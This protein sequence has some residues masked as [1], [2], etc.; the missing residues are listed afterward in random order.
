MIRIDVL[1]SEAEIAREFLSGLGRRYLEE[2]FFYWFPLSVRA[3]LRLCGDVAY[4]NFVRSQ[5]LLRDS[6]PDVARRL[7]PGPVTVVSLGSG[8]GVKDVLVLESLRASGREPD[9]A[10]VD[11][12]QSLLE[13]ACLEA[14]GRGFACRGVKADLADAAHLE[15]LRPAPNDSPRL[16][17]LLGNTLGAFDPLALA[18]DVASLLRASDRLLIDGEIFSEA[19][20]MAGYDNPINREFAS[21]PL[22]AAGLTEPADGALTFF[23]ESDGRLEG[24]HRVRK[25][26]EVG[27]A[28]ELFLA[29]ESL[30][31]EAGE[32]IEM[33]WS[34]KYSVEAFDAVLARGG[35][36]ALASYPSGDGCFRMVLGGKG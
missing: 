13:M 24:L 16:F 22:R 21:A 11:A 25:R 28:V 26:F 2:K 29:G 23:S 18:K 12:S 19:A 5:T 1:L 27:R 4:R 33:S 36:A 30:G 6:L 35:I 7:G 8:Q 9:Y 31:F 10:P 17:M 15:S 32:R 14:S 34:Y 3:W 20:T